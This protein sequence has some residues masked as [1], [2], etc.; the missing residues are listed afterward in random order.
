MTLVTKSTS[1]QGVC[2]VKINRPEKLNA[3]NTDVAREL[4]SAFEEIGLDSS[5]KVVVLTGEGEK[6]FSAGADIEYMSEISADESVEYA[7]LGQLV[8]ATVEL[9]RQPTIAAV[10]GFALG[11]GCEL[12]MSC[13]IRIAADTARMGQPE[14]TIGIPPGWG[15]TQR[16]MRIVGIAK[17][18]ELVYTGKM[19]KADEAREMGLVNAVVPLAD[20]QAEAEKMA[21]QIAANSEMG[22]RMSKVAI[23]RGRNAD[24]D[25]GLSIELLAWRNC[26]THPDRKERMT[27]FVNKSKKN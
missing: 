5:V 19:V 24:L 22:V 17:A 14:V 12:A 26:F 27:A 15:G 21:L 1:E 4:V 25:T 6:A 16:L 10:N 7:K 2:T 18:K 9:V 23:N 13:D 11:G 20:L 3:M 8:T